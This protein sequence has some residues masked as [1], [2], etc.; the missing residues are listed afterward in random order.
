MVWEVF[1]QSNPPEGDSYHMEYY[2]KDS[3]KQI[4]AYLLKK[5]KKDKKMISQYLAYAEH[6]IEKLQTKL[7]IEKNSG[8]PALDLEKD[9]AR[10]KDIFAKLSNLKETLPSRN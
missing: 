9:I 10:V 2:D 4:E 7:Q 1:D 6:L 3:M 5:S 8:N